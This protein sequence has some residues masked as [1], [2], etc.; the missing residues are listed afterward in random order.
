MIAYELLAFLKYLVLSP[1]E[2]G[3]IEWVGT[4]KQWKEA[5]KEINNYETFI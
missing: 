5:N 3:K 1:D 2:N 4:D